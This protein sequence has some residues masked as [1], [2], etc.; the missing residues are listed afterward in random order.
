Y[1]QCSSVCGKGER[2]RLVVCH[3]VD[4]RN[5]TDD[6]CE[7][8]KP[9]D[10]QICD[11]GSCA[12]GWF[13]SPWSRKCFPSCG[14]GHRS[15][16][17]YCSSPDG[18]QI[19]EAKCQS[20]KPKQKK[21][22][23]NKRP[24][25]GYWFAG[26]WSECSSTCGSGVQER[27]VICVKKLDKKLFTIVG[28]ENCRGRD[29]PEME[30]PC[31]QLPPCQPQWFMTP[32]TQCSASC[33]TG[34]RTREVRCMDPELAPSSTCTANKKPSQQN[35]CNTQPCTDE[36]VQQD[37]SCKDVYKFCRLAG[38]ARLCSY[39][40]YQENCCSSCQTYQH[41]KTKEKP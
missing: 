16:Q 24:C 19:S 4:D 36:S 10:I 12:Q 2:R 17:V 37:P 30:R 1:S 6:Q 3:S 32:W 26:P 35:I 41:R 38:P 22:C 7:G 39:P 28:K 33:G 29:K 31:E 15:R 14:R 5:V 27:S 25:G 8:L 34:T 11:M 21:A 13:H 18:S 23:R 40:F 9:L 20:K